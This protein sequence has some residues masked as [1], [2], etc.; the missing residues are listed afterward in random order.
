M[1]GKFQLKLWFQGREG[2]CENSTVVKIQGVPIN[3]LIY[4]KLQGVTINKL[5]YILRNTIFSRYT[6]WHLSTIGNE[7]D[8]QLSLN[9]HVYFDTL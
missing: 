1:Q 6:F 8:F 5:P 4:I 3:R 2:N 9:S 7:D